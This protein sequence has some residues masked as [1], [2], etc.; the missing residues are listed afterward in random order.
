MGTSVPLCKTMWSLKS[1]EGLTAA[2]AAS[3][4][5]RVVQR[6]AMSESLFSRFIISS[7]KQYDQA[8]FVR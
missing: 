1:V 8:G 6:D 2:L 5:Q 3:V 7:L 4:K